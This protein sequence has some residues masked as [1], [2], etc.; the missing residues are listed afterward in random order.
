[1]NLPR[2][3]LHVQNPDLVKATGKQVNPS[4][5]SFGPAQRFTPKYKQLGDDR[6]STHA[7]SMIRRNPDGT[8]DYDWAKNVV[9][10]AVHNAATP[11]AILP[12]HLALLQVVFPQR[13]RSMEPQQAALLT[14]LSESEKARVKDLVE[15]H[16]KEEENWNAGAGGSS[17]A[18]RHITR[19]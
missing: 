1:M 2:I 9:I 17:I 19:G 6:P 11:H 8:L 15:A 3:P 14:Q 12:V 16:L 10:D 13:F 7:M 4:Y 5:E 18:G